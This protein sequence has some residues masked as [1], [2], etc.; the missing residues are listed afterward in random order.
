MELPKSWTRWARTGGERAGRHVLDPA[1][2]RE[3]ADL[4]GEL[5]ADDVEART[6]AGWF[7]W[8]RYEAAPQD[9]GGADLEAAAAVLRPLFHENPRRLPGPVRRF[10]EQVPAAASDTPGTTHDNAM[11]L[12]TIAERTHS[13]LL[14]DR[15]VRML[16]EAAERTSPDDADL[17]M[18]LSNLGKALYGRYGEQDLL[19]DLLRSVQLARQ[20]LDLTPVDAPQLSARWSVLGVALAESYRRSGDNA[21]L[22]EAVGAGRTAVDLSRGHPQRVTILM[23]ATSALIA[24]YEATGRPGE[25]DRAVQVAE[26]A[27]ELDSAAGRED[28]RRLTNLALALRHRFELSDEPA[29]IDRAVELAR[30]AADFG[31]SPDRLGNLGSILSSRYARGGRR[32]D[33][34][35]AVEAGRAAVALSDHGHPG[36]SLRLAQLS[37]SLRQLAELDACTG[38]LDEA[39]RHAE[40]AVAVVPDGHQEQPL[41]QVALGTALQARHARLGGLA[42]LE[43]AVVLLRDAYARM[44]D[45]AVHRATCATNLSGALLRRFE[46][47]GHPLDL[48]DAVALGRAAVDA[49]PAGSPERSGRLSNLGIALTELF[50]QAGR[51]EDLTAAATAI[52][53]A[54]AGIG[55]D[56]PER[57]IYLAN[58]AGALSGVARRSRRRADVEEA[59]AVARSAVAVAGSADSTAMANLGAV[60]LT[61]YTF[62]AGPTDLDD[63]VV[64]ARHAVR[65]EPESSPSHTLF[66]ANLAGLLLHRWTAAPTPSR[67]ADLE[68]ALDAARRSLADSDE[69]LPDRT[70]RLIHVGIALHRSGRRPGAPPD[71]NRLGEALDV[72]QQA[73]MTPTAT[74]RIRIRAAAEWADAAVTAQRM[75]VAHEALSLAVGL[76]G[77]LTTRRLD[78]ADQE[79]ELADLYGLAADAAACALQAAG[80][81][82]ALVLLEQGRGVLLQQLLDTRVDLTDLQAREPELAARFEQLCAALDAGPDVP[83]TVA[84][85]LGPDRLPARPTGRQALAAELEELIERIRTVPEFARFLLPPDI[86][87]LS[88]AASGGPVVVVNVSRYG[89]D[90]L[91]LTGTGVEQVALPAVDVDT[92]YEHTVEFVRALEDIRDPGRARARGECEAVLHDTLAWLWNTVA[93]PVLDHLAIGPAASP[94]RL[95]WCPTGVLSL[96]PLHAAGRHRDAGAAAARTVPALVVSSY[97]TT[98][99]ALLH[100]RQRRRRT[101]RPRTSRTAPRG[102]AVVMPRTPGERDLPGAVEEAALFSRALGGRVTTLVGQQAVRS[103]VLGAVPQHAWAHFACHAYSDLDDPARSRLLVHDH[104]GTPLTVADLYRMRL[105]D[106]E[107]AFLSACSTARVA[108]GLADEAAHLLSGFQLAGYDHVIGTLWPVP[109]RSSLRVADRL[110]QALGEGGFEADGCAAALHEAVARLARGWPDHP[111]M[112]AAYVHTGP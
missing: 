48:D 81:E 109:D 56:H 43:R 60:L 54:V 37:L 13:R 78:R 67:A 41:R 5:A 70:R 87:R 8:D 39:V 49:T 58:L 111:S 59:L 92:V 90:A 53:A 86:S 34:A 47:T 14:L 45:T 94:P 71:D 112:W 17:P 19:G 102:L 30:R 12:L 55:D 50:D 76:L 33:L 28:P 35:D 103:E 7:Y 91:I 9:A 85:T 21:V 36:S 22:K 46:A 27:V 80:P 73:A 51:R 98:V 95:W 63:A 23:N 93:E 26:E 106:A 107:L 4:V 99:R 96:L 2:D 57:A 69:G 42:D 110:Y 20:A 1:L 15:C 64:A 75:D 61:R 62:T 44:P 77:R 25:L 31:Q 38:L 3:I 11:A 100:T 101:D 6:R 10:F 52:R 24:S 82:A 89:S 105:V 79:H 83:G 29:D 40:Q 66:L 65:A 104:R 97:T 74:P 72:L 16:E 84:P 32:Q 108:P 88:A 18:L 68:E